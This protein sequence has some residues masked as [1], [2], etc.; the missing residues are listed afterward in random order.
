M[1]IGYDTNISWIGKIYEVSVWATFYDATTVKGLYDNCRL[2]SLWN[3]TLDCIDVCLTGYYY[4][5]TE[6]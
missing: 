1:Y 3:N 2:Y 5:S 6:C 4:V